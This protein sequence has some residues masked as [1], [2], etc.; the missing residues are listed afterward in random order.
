M[1]AGELAK[2]LN[3]DLAGNPDLAVTG[4]S[5]EKNASGGDVV[6]VRNK[7]NIN[8][9]RAGVVVTAPCFVYTDKTLLFT[10]DNLDDVLIR[11]CRIFVKHGLMTDYAKPVSYE[12]KEHGIGIGCDVTIAEHVVIEPGVLIG[13]HVSIASGTVIESGAKIGSGTVIGKD[14]FI[15]T[16]A[17]VGAD[18]FF[19][20]GFKEWKRFKGMGRVHVC[21]RT[22]IG[23]HTVVQRGTLSDTV[24]GENCM[25]GNFVDIGHDVVIGKNCKIVSQ[26]GI[27]GNAAIGNNVLICGQAG[28]SNFVRIGDNAV[29]KAK[30]LVSKS[31]KENTA[32]FGLYGREFHEELRLQAGIK[33]YL[34]RKR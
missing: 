18:S 29:V 31:V 20:Y 7:K 12:M 15:A 11:I 6:I 8:R 5:Y 13:D 17:V 22:Q 30:T 21:D 10:Y 1:K 26:T 14:V 33:K 25:I 9:T 3:F 34:E 32:V 28:I 27:A 19:H 2:E 24:I 16:G 4:I 23:S